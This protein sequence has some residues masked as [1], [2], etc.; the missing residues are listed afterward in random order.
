M[1]RKLLY[2]IMA[3]LFLV[4][5]SIPVFA[6]WT[7]AKLNPDGYPYTE[8]VGFDGQEAV[9]LVYYTDVDRPWYVGAG[10][11]SRATNSWTELNPAGSMFSTAIDVSD[12]QQVGYV[13]ISTP[14]YY[15]DC[16]CMWSG[17]ADS[18]VNLN[19]EG[20]TCSY[21]TGISSGQE[22]GCAAINGK[23]HAGLWHGTAESWTDLNPGESFQSS[24][25]GISGNQIVGTILDATGNHACIWEGDSHDIV[26]LNPPGVAY[27]SATGVSN[28]QQV[29][30]VSMEDNSP[31]ACL[32]N[33]SASSFVDLHPNEAELSEATATHNN[34]QVGSAYSNGANHASLWNGTPESWIDLSNFL[35]DTKYINSWATGVYATDRDIWVTG[36]TQWITTL[37]GGG[38]YCSDAFIWHFAYVPEMDIALRL[39]HVNGSAGDNVTLHSAVTNNGK[40]VTG[41]NVRFSVD[42]KYIGS[43]ISDRKGAELAFDIPAEMTVGVHDATASFSGDE[44]YNISS[45]TASVLRVHSNKGH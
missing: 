6:G 31:H 40:S 22:V 25:E 43:A 33:G 35:S 19:P 9:G 18:F 8:V 3:I 13:T 20:S 11:W 41:L 29:G 12:G 45:Q 39:K 42:G 26:Y 14:E 24:A 2:L 44:T 30:Y 32:W 28:G 38:F 21:A 37:Y 15:R 17:T 23:M 7:V 36:C 1:L 10:F 16:A 27:S 34:Y 5:A 4:L